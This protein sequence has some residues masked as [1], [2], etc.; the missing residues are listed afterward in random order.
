MIDKVL[1]LEEWEAEH[2]QLDAEVA[3]ATRLGVGVSTALLTRA[4]HLNNKTDAGR[5]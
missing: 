5:G 4:R 2:Q 3:E 1:T